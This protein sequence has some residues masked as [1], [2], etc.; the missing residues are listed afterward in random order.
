MPFTR[1]TQDNT[2]TRIL[3][4]GTPNTGKTTSSE[5]F[6]T[7][8]SDHMILLNCPGEK[9]T[10]SIPEHPQIEAYRYE[11]PEDLT[12]ESSTAIVKDFKDLTNYA[13]KQSPTI[14]WIDGIHKL[15]PL[16][17]NDLSAGQFFD[18]GIVTQQ[19]KGGE[20]DVTGNTY[21]RCHYL[22]GSYL[23]SLYDSRI[24]LVV[25]TAWE[26]WENRDENLTKEQQKNAVKQLWP[27][28]PGKMAK[29]IVGE[30]DARISARVER[31][32]FHK[33]CESSKN[34]RDH[35]VWQVLPKNDVAGVGIKG[36]RKIPKALAERP[37]IH[38][39]WSVLKE[40][41]E[42]CR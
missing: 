24:P 41:M 38:Q 6:I 32:C 1:M 16:M 5:T 2:R 23:S 3:I 12:P 4:S 34:S 27:M 30:F 29:L 20:L 21:G 33:D 28:L 36:L 31:R 35:F 9:G 42:H 10:K 17:M 8:D 18:E 11:I 26:D 37:F 19:T 14:L 40:L 15:Y 25:V 39:E 7:L 22:F 13:V